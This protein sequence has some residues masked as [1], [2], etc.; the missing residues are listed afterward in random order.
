MNC[1]LR[2]RTNPLDGGHGHVL[3][4]V[5]SEVSKP[6][7]RVLTHA[8]HHIRKAGPLQ[9]TFIVAALMGSISRADDPPQIFLDKN[10]RIIAYQLKRLS[11]PQLLSLERKT[12][13]AKYKPIYEAILARKG[14]ERK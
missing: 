9:I 2:R 13:E 8:T 11:N 3:M 14:V 6:R 5:A 12:S 1:T 7:V 10:P 4:P